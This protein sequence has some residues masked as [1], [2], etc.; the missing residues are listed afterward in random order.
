[1]GAQSSAFRLRFNDMLSVSKN[2]ASI[3]NSHSDYDNISGNHPQGSISNRALDPEQQSPRSVNALQKNM[4]GS[5]E[6][7]RISF[8]G[9]Q[10]KKRGGAPKS[11]FA[12]NGSNQRLVERAGS[13]KNRGHSV[14]SREESKDSHFKSSSLS[15]KAL[16]GNPSGK[17]STFQDKKASL[18]NEMLGGSIDISDNE[19][20][21][22]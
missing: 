18:N 22:G 4:R 17:S 8:F 21:M 16:K 1:M 9:Q 12:A 15:N 14:A 6:G 13:L 19:G 5:S 11:K 10:N 20:I 7:R 3:S 2:S